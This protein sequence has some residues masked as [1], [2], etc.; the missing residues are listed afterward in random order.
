VAVRDSYIGAGTLRAG[1]LAEVCAVVLGSRGGG[2]LERALASIAWAGERIVLD[3]ANRLAAEALPAG[4]RRERGPRPEDVTSAPWLL[5]LDEDETA[6]PALATAVAE[7]IRGETPLA[8]YRIGQEVHA[9]GTRLRPRRDAVRLARRDGTRLALGRGLTPALSATGT[10]GQLAGV[11][12]KEGA[13][14]LGEAVDDLDAYASVL[15]ALLDDAGARPGIRA[16]VIAF[17]AAG[18]RMLSAR[19]T[20]TRPWSRWSLALLA[21]YRAMVA[22]AKLW[23][24]RWTRGVAAP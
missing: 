9:L 6:P 4:V 20:T 23:E 17:L 22:Y 11:L 7:A 24:L 5:L 10:P 2:R 1:E 13:G 21:G 12:E 16:S 19:G 15:A 14:S 18:G 3:P 8:S